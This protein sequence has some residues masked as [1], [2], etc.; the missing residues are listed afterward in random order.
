MVS[1][2]DGLNDRDGFN[3]SLVSMVSMIDD[4]ND[5]NSSM[6]ILQ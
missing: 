5:T 4:F 1:M 3:D 2:I 6:I